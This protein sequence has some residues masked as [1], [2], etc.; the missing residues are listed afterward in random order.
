MN[1]KPLKPCILFLSNNGGCQRHIALSISA[2]P[3]LADGAHLI[4]PSLIAEPGEGDALQFIDVHAS[5]FSL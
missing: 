5:H 3:V 4:L 2:F 1:G